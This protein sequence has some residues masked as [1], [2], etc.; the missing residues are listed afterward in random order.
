MTNPIEITVG[1][2]NVGAE[3][4]EHVF[5]NVSERDRYK[6]VKRILDFNPNIYGLIFCRTRRTT[7]DVADKLL[8]EGYSAAPLHGDLSQMQ[9]DKAMEKFREKTIQVLVATDVAA[10]GI[11]VNNITH[12]INFH[13][14]D[15][16]ESYTHRSG[17]TARAGN[18]G[19]SIAIVSNKDRNKISQIERKVKIKFE[20]GKLPSGKEICEQQLIEYVNKIK[21]IKINEEEISKLL[22]SINKSFEEF[23]KDEL[24]KRMIAIEFSQLLKYYENSREISSD[25]GG[26]GPRISNEDHQRF[27]INLGH[28]KGLNKGGLLRLICSNTNLPAKSVGSLDLY[29]DFSFFEVDKKLSD[30]I[31]E[32]LKGKEY[33]NKS[34]VVE[35]ASKDGSKR[36]GDRN[37]G[38]DRKRG[39]DRDRNRGR[40]RD[41]NKRRR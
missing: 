26:K 13:L 35:I 41:R 6:A 37:R 39:R 25:K 1:N 19:V 28:N 27:F 40:D 20:E 8:K 29:N 17:R 30:K 18:K 24:I 14:P 5:Y 12:V 2:K 11:D 7:Q 9:R 38:R 16:S 36:R 34:F 31:L 23:S 15:E 3:N 32:D 4:I 21:N 10:R 22:P 33:D